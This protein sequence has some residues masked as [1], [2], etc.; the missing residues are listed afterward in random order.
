MDQLAVAQFSFAA[1]VVVVA[2]SAFASAAVSVVASAAV[3]ALHGAVAFVCVLFV[4]IAAAEAW[5][6]LLRTTALAALGDDGHA[7]WALVC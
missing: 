2:A 6:P 3:P 5:A 4:V 1:A 7:L